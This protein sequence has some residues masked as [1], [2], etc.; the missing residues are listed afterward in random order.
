ME[1]V[2]ILHLEDSCLDAELAQARLQGAGIDCL[3]DRVETRDTFTAAL[4]NG[5]YDLI[6]S[7]Y[8]LPDFDG[9]TALDLAH[10]LRPDIPFIFVSGMLGEEVAIDTLKRGATDYVLKQRLDRLGPAVGRALSEVRERK[11]RR[12]TESALRDQND[13]TR[14]ITDNATASLFMVDAGGCCTFINPA[15][16]RELGFGMSEAQQRPLHDLLHANETST[17]CPGSSCVLRR[18]L[19]NGETLRE[20][21]DLFIGPDGTP[22]PVMCAASPIMKAGIPAGTVLEVRNVSAEKEA[23]TLLR[24]HQAD[25]EALNERLQRAMTETHHR[26]KNNLQIIAAMID[27]Q[28]MENQPTFQH[29]GIRSLE[30]T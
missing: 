14:A 29:S 22:F 10:N 9:A 5:P 17:V 12:E 24:R 15:A 18:A 3:V 13:I 16:Q 20:H 8:A 23:E 19:L 7:D 2:R 27:M 1:S 11:R 4:K 21:E 30:F 28:A 6:L 26:V 25:I